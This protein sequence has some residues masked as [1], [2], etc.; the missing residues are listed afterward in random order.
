[1]TLY[2]YD[3]QLMK[4][5]S[6]MN[7]KQKKDAYKELNKY[8]QNN[9]PNNLMLL[10]RERYDFTVFNLY[11]I[12]EVSNNFSFTKDLTEVIENRGEWLFCEYD[13]NNNGFE[14][15]IEIEGEPYMYLLFPCEDFIINSNFNM[16]EE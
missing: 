7:N 14:I 11:Y 2:E 1:M 10:C 6:V 3:K 15:W 4:N 13:E 12:K 5:R 16:C 8:L 9:K